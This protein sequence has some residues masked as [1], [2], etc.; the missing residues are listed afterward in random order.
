M[1]ATASKYWQD[2]VKRLALLLLLG[3]ATE[4]FAQNAAKPLENW[5]RICKETNPPL[6]DPRLTGPLTLEQLKTCYNSGLYYGL[7]GIKQDYAAALQCG[8][9]EWSH[10]ESGN[11]NGD[12][13]NGAG[14][15][16]MLYANGQGVARNYDLA[17]RFACEYR[18]EQKGARVEHLDALRKAFSA[19]NPDKTPFDVCN[20]VTGSVS[21]GEC[22]AV[23]L[24]LRNVPLNR[25]I[26]A[27]TNKLTASQKRSFE[28]VRAAEEKFN[29]IRLD[30]EIDLKWPWS[31]VWVVQDQ[32]RLNEQ[33][34]IN[35][36]RFSK[37]DVPQ[38][39][40]KDVK[41]LDSQMNDAY[42]KVMQAPASGFESVSVTREG[43]RS[44][45]RAWLQLRDAWLEFSGT[46]YPKLSAE[47][48][49]SDAILG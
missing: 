40:T 41:A 25:E 34:L 38:A 6:V 47:R 43:V 20:D 11:A 26:A 27:L 36:Q 12:I 44:A 49:E 32:E 37:G 3:C 5:E 23:A 19:G 29:A 22:G 42:Q 9:Y 1:T 35:L 45:Q 30:N 14:I 17:I 16:M 24:E 28:K 8:W 21:S 4:A 15:L 31:R 18:W 7:S 13:Y 48:V 33:F 2:L 46:T 10:P 39:T